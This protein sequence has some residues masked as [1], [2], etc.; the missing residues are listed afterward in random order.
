MVKHREIHGYLRTSCWDKSRYI[1]EVSA[2]PN[3]VIT[4]SFRQETS[5]VLIVFPE[6]TENEPQ[7]KKKIP[8]INY[9]RTKACGE[10]ETTIDFILN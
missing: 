4:K 3:V 10:I 2:P 5:N 1:L 8:I 7:E 6:Q 9:K